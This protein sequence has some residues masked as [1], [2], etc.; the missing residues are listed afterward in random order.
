[1]L[2][3]KI[4]DEMLSFYHQEFHVLLFI[5]SNYYK[6]QSVLCVKMWIAVD[7]NVDVM[8]WSYMFKHIMQ[9]LHALTCKHI[10]IWDNINDI[11]I[12]ELSYAY[13]LY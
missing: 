4:S 8:I 11:G 5:G 2:S 12:D 7:T 10:Y 13:D 3:G 1:M 9:Y 6:C